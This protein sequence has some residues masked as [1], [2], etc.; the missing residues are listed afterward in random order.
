[1]I[2]VQKFVESF[3]KHIRFNHFTWVAAGSWYNWYSS[4]VHCLLVLTQLMTSSTESF[5]AFPQVPS[6]VCYVPYQPIRTNRYHITTKAYHIF[7]SYSWLWS[8]S[9]W[10]RV[11]FV[12]KLYI[13]SH[14]EANYLFCLELLPIF[15]KVLLNEII[16]ICVGFVIFPQSY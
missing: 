6:L 3:L 15:I 2:I 12:Q 11:F 1:M 13:D 7:L 16:V 5:L 9:Q 4:M 8:N 10:G 14:T